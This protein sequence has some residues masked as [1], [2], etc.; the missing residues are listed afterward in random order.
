MKIFIS[1][2]GQKSKKVAEALRE[3]LPNVIQALEPWMSS[4]DINKGA[5][6][7]VDIVSE[8]EKTHFGIIVLTPDNV[9]TP[10]ILFEAGALSKSLSKALVCPYLFGIDSANLKGPLVQFQLT[11]ST[12]GDTE[13]LLRSINQAMSDKSLP[14]E[15]LHN[16]FE[17]WWPDLEEKFKVI[18][19]MLDAHR[20]R[21]SDRELLEEILDLTRALASDNMPKLPD[22]EY[23]KS[24]EFI[25]KVRKIALANSL[26]PEHIKQHISKYGAWDGPLMEKDKD[27]ASE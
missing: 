13:K 24:P 4:E 26:L 19:S 18:S 2:S 14:A 23:F 16:A 3:W 20:P 12:K 5:R 25:D 11:K 6:W 8:L 1:W 17:R 15:N 27:A 22:R 9:E 10:W 21:R 7:Y